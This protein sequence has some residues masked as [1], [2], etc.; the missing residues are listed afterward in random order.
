[1]GIKDEEEIGRLDIV[2]QAIYGDIQLH[3]DQVSYLFIYLFIIYIYLFIY[4]YYYSFFIEGTNKNRALHLWSLF[5]SFTHTHTHSV[6]EIPFGRFIGIIPL[7]GVYCDGLTD[8]R[9]ERRGPSFLFSSPS[10]PPLLSLSSAWDGRRTIGGR[11]QGGGRRARTTRVGSR[12][13]TIWPRL[14]VRRPQKRTLSS[15]P[16]C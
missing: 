3:K 13:R 6:K 1:M 15:T 9:T 16:S 4:Y 8:G 12:A 2:T 7:W 10:L 14:G 5:L 11:M